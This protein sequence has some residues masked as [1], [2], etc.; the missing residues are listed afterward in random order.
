MLRRQALLKISAVC[1][2]LA[3]S[4]CTPSTPTFQNTDITGADFGKNFTLTD[5]TGKTRSLSDYQGKVVLIFFGF[6]QCPDVCPTTLAELS[7]V[8][9]KLGS[10]ADRVQVLF[11]T[12]DPERDTQTVL[13]QYVPAFDPRFVGL[14]GSVEQIAAVAKDFKAFYQKVPTPNGSYTVDHFSGMYAF[15]ATGRI[16]LFI[17]YRA[18]MDSVVADVKTLLKG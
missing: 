1:A 18:P 5:H 12:V 17:R 6:T 15:D 3:L 11:I 10:G 14:T 7:E 9:K 13:G 4:G 8:M 16:R 2:A